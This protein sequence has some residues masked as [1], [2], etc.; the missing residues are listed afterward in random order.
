MDNLNDW[1]GQAHAKDLM[2]YTE[3]QEIE[4]LTLEP[5]LCQEVDTAWAAEAARRLEQFERGESSSF[6][7]DE[8][9]ARFGMA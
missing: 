9:R 6:S 3:H 7:S 2:P 4:A 1:A 8:V 5:V